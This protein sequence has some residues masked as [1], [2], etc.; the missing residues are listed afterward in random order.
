MPRRP[1]CHRTATPARRLDHAASRPTKRHPGT[2]SGL[3]DA[4]GGPAAARA[5]RGGRVPQAPY[6][7]QARARLARATAGREAAQAVHWRRAWPGLARSA[8]RWR[9]R[10]STSALWTVQAGWEI[11]LF[12]STRASRDAAGQRAVVAQLNL[13]QAQVSLDVE[14]AQAL[15][16]WRHADAQ[17]RLVPKTRPWLNAWPPL[18]PPRPRPAC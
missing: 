15:L 14:V 8:A 9:R 1:Q 5:D 10:A 6:L 7:A 4:A 3:V 2:A 11:D 12:G 13:D 17:T 18:T 16:A